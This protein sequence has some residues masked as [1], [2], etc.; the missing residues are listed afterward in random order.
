[1]NPREYATILWFAIIFIFAEIKTHG[2]IDLN[3][4][5]TGISLL[6][7]PAILII[8]TYQI[9]VFPFIFKTFNK[10]HLSIWGIK[11]YVIVL[12]LTVFPFSL[13]FY[14][15]SYLHNLIKSLSISAIVKFL[16]SYYTFSFIVELLLVPIIFFLVLLASTT[17]S[18]TNLAA[19]KLSNFIFIVIELSIIIYFLVNFINDFSSI[20]KLQ[21]WEGFLAE[22]FTWILN[23]PLIFL[24]LPLFQ[25]DEIDNFSK[26]K[27]VSI[28]LL[29]S[30][31]F[32]IKR[33]LYLFTLFV[34]TSNCL[35]HV[36]QGGL[37]QRNFIL[38]FKDQ[39][40]EEKMQ[41]IMMRV[42][43]MLMPIKFYRKNRKVI[44]ISVV[45]KYSSEPSKII[46]QWKEP[47]FIDP[48]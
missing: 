44:P 18:S 17:D 14:R 3:F 31:T 36:Q 45:C 32:W 41:F 1:M 20:M 37:N 42:R 16:L 19:K 2:K 5:S 13:G 15:Q 39:V 46:L 6:R 26:Q 12:I 28:L 10:L 48:L 9:I 23:L 38:F 30:L 7:E 22:P 43:L 11:D 24:C 40:A 35:E 29:Q 47:K 21:Y 27:N 25:Y 8:I 33:F 4:I 34:H